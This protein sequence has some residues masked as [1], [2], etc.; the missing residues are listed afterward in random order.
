MKL[1]LLEMSLRDA[2]HL[3]YGRNGRPALSGRGFLHQMA[4]ATT[5]D[6][7]SQ[8]MGGTGFSGDG[9]PK[10]KRHRQYFRMANP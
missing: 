1:E 6:H 9:M 5:V 8:A 3:I 7:N 10:K 2:L 4:A